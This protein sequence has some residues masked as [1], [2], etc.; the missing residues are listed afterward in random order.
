MSTDYYS[1][2]DGEDAC[3]IGIVKALRSE[4]Y[5]AFPR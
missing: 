2:K 4:L 3:D 1:T 5:K